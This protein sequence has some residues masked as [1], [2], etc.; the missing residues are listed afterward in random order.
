[1]VVRAGEKAARG[2]NR[3]KNDFAALP[4][5]IS[6]LGWIGKSSAT[7]RGAEFWETENKDFVQNVEF[8]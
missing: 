5:H 3:S 1:M 2:G 4:T 8:V 6:F 7:L